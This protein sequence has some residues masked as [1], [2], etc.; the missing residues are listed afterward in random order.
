MRKI[1]RKNEDIEEAQK[2]IGSEDPIFILDKEQ[3]DVDYK[4]E[5]MENIPKSYYRIYYGRMAMTEKHT[6]K[7]IFMVCFSPFGIPNWPCTG[8]PIEEREE[9][10]KLMTTLIELSTT[11]NEVKDNSSCKGGSGKMF[12]LGWRGGYEKESS[13]SR[14]H[15]TGK[16]KKHEK[17]LKKWEK[18]QEEKVT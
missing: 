13:C 14:Y 7:L 1:R 10:S 4:G 15:P 16:I 9:F 18:Q 6:R 2:K 5:F 17:D 11:G 8:M 12:A 3:C